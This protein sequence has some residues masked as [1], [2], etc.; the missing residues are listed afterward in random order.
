M[1]MEVNLMQWKNINSLLKGLV[2]ILIA[3]YAFVS[4]FNVSDSFLYTYIVIAIA[5]YLVGMA[6]WTK[7]WWVILLSAVI[8]LFLIPMYLSA[9]VPDNS[10]NWDVDQIYGYR[11]YLLGLMSYPA[12]G[13]VI[14]LLQKHTRDE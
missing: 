4:T 5:N 13:L 10:L 1:T 2:M 12:I 14:N 6:I 11:P 7:R 9:S 8:G 3:I